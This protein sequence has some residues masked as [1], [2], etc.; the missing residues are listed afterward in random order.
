MNMR[1]IFNRLHKSKTESEASN[2]RVTPDMMAAAI[3]MLAEEHA[4]AIRNDLSRIAPVDPVLLHRAIEELIRAYWAF[5]LERLFECFKGDELLVSLFY[6]GMANEMEATFPQYPGAMDRA[7]Q[8]QAE[9]LHLVPN[10]NVLS[11]EYS[12]FVEQEYLD[13]EVP[14]ALRF[15]ALN[16]R[17]CQL[18]GFTTGTPGYAFLFLHTGC[19]LEGVP[20]LLGQFEPTFRES[21]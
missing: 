17:L 14:W 11:T 16:A 8:E 9:Q 2:V 6:T 5:W 19:T 3:V 12:E 7:L 21:A 1:L 4:K 20:S 15:V 10:R 13:Q 18:F